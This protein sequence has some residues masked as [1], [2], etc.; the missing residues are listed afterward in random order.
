MHLGASMI[1]GWDAKEIILMCLIVMAILNY[2]GCLKISMG[3]KDRF[4]CACC[5]RG[6]IKAC[7][8]FNA[9]FNI[10]IIRRAFF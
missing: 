8:V 7:F 5:T 2:T 6:K 3:Q 9:Y 4:W 1:E 10:R